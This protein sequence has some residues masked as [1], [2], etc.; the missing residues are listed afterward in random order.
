[1]EFFFM[2]GFRGVTLHNIISSRDFN[3]KL[4]H[5]GFGLYHD[6][7]MQFRFILGTLWSTPRSFGEGCGHIFRILREIDKPSMWRCS[8]RWCWHNKLFSVDVC[9]DVRER[10]CVPYH[11]SHCDRGTTRGC[12]KSQIFVLWEF[13]LR[14]WG[15]KGAN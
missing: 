15:E 4:I 2:L 1:M 10:N 12:G 9:G 6:H 7:H 11:F 8:W 5:K 3:K 14:V 13:I